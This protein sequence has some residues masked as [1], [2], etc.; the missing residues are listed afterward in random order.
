MTAIGAWLERHMDLPRRDCEVL[1]GHT[2]KLDRSQILA[3]PEREV[4]ETDLHNLAAA[5][6]RLRA[7]EPIAYVTGSREF[8]GHEFAVSAA[9]L[10]PRP[11]T[12]LLVD[13]ALEKLAGGQRV[14]DLGTGSGAVAVS[15][16]LAGSY[17]VSATDVSAAALA[18]ARGNARRLGATVT[19]LEGAWFA[20]V[21]GRFHVIVSNPPYVAECDPHLESLRFEPTAALVSGPDGLSA[22]RDITAGAAGHLVPGG[23]LL[24]EHGFDQGGAVRGLLVAA[25]F[26]NVDTRRD[27][28]GHERVTMGQQPDAG[29]A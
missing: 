23:W 19:F 13:L 11:D 4:D 21:S 12:E 24:L 9:V 26:H 29:S 17:E 7:G 22:I 8:Y 18:A 2:L 6:A 25:G 16:A 14:L 3:F 1:L 27:L 10:I 15:L 5:A 28:A 20:P